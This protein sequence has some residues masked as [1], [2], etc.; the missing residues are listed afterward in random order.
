MAHPID[1]VVEKVTRRTLKEFNVDFVFLQKKDSSFFRCPSDPKE[2]CI[3]EFA[4]SND[5]ENIKTIFEHIYKC[6]RNDWIEI[7]KNFK[8]W[9][10]EKKNLFSSTASSSS[11]N[12]LNQT[13]LTSKDFEDYVDRN[14]SSSTTTTKDYVNKTFIDKDQRKIMANTFH[15]IFSDFSELVNKD[16][17]TFSNSG[18][19]V[20]ELKGKIK[21][22]AANLIKEVEKL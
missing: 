17:K 19:N 6:H 22:H 21:A 13:I 14:I 4:N 7:T 20:N 10:I 3:D 12:E 1:V 18:L 11:I 15:E 9:Y 2:N 5:F 16:I 8:D